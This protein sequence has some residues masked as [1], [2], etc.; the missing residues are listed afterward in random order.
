[1]TKYGETADSWNAARPVV[2]MSLVVALVV[3]PIC[4]LF[5]GTLIK[6]RQVK[7]CTTNGKHVAGVLIGEAGDRTYVGKT[8]SSNVAHPVVSIPRSEIIQT[9]I[10]SYTPVKAGCPPPP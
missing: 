8:G 7:V 3:A 4:F 6:L 10:G 2:Y 1:V 9:I 5:A